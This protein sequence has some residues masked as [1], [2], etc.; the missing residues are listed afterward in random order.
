[1]GS[2]SQHLNNHDINS[3]SRMSEKI[4]DNSINSATRL[5]QQLNYIVWGKSH[6]N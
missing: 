4:N 3:V 2:L 6:K 5:S 1:M